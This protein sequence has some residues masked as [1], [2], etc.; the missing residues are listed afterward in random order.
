MT[1][2]DA[3]LGLQLG[4]HLLVRLGVDQVEQSRGIVQAAGQLI[5]R[6]DDGLE[7]P[8]RIDDLASPLEVVPE[9]RFGLLSLKLRQPR[10]LGVE[11]KG[12]LGVQS[13]GDRGRGVVRE[14]RTSNASPRVIDEPPVR[15]RR[16]NGSCRFNPLI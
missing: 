9:P 14:A 6:D 3:H 5:G 16:R 11:V 2:D 1:L 15:W 10:P 12:N 4:Q 7:P 8:N 13:G